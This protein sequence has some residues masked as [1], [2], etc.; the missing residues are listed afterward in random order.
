MLCNAIPVTL[1]TKK[2]DNYLKIIH[3]NI[4]EY[5]K[6]IVTV[7]FFTWVLDYSIFDLWLFN[8]VWTE[9]HMAIKLLYNTISVSMP[10]HF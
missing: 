8:L 5:E 10:I 1:Q 6:S 7:Q 3:E 2:I 9:Y 4:V